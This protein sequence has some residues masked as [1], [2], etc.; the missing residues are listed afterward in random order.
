[1]K[2]LTEDRFYRSW[3]EE[4]EGEV[5]FHVKLETTDLYI[6]ADRDLSD[7]AAA[8]VRR[9]RA[10]LNYHIAANPEFATSLKPLE[11][12]KGELGPLVASMYR[13]AKLTEVGPMAA[14]AGTVSQAIASEL[15][16]HSRCVMVE[17]GGDIYVDAD[18]EVTIAIYAG[19]S[20][21]NGKVA[22]KL[23]ASQLPL[24]VCT[25]SGLVGPSLSY[26]RAQAATVI[27][28]DAALADAAA[29][30]LG[31]RIT[32]AAD[33]AEALEWTVAIEGVTGALAIA[34]DNLG[35]MGDVTLIQL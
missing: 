18:R 15:R 20:K 32:T 10:T 4:A 19:D 27:S 6:R 31:N 11:P 13:A 7:E 3:G 1:M 22:I 16:R 14:V 33:I 28:A 24:A 9:T 23:D 17:N 25:S 34:E 29:T 35:I 26:G 5:T 2:G 30:A 21:L 8:A 12:P